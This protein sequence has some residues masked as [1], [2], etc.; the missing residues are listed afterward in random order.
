MKLK[1]GRRNV[2]YS[3]KYPS[4]YWC[5]TPAIDVRRKSHRSQST[6]RQSSHRMEPNIWTLSSIKNYDSN[7]VLLKKAPM[8]QWHLAS[9]KVSGG[10]H[11]CIQGLCHGS[12]LQ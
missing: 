4:M 1:N 7:R 2:E 6:E 3:L 12:G 9:Q 8:Q 5:I 11:T 10:L